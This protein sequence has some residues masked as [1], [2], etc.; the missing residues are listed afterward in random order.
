M[1][2]GRGQGGGKIDRSYGRRRRRKKGTVF[3]RRAAMLSPRRRNI[4]HVR[5][6]GCVSNEFCSS[7]GCLTSKECGENDS[8]KSSVGVTTESAGI[9]VIVPTPFSPFFPSI[10][11]MDAR[12]MQSG[13][14][15]PGGKDKAGRRERN[16]PGNS[17]PE[18]TNWSDTSSLHAGKSS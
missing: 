6:V 10:E 16:F 4:C 9:F 5:P 17:S 18:M 15:V 13:N 7:K 14:F 11:G 12:I 8:I 1:D 3:P 2:K